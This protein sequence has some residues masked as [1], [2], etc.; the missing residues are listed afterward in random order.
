[1]KFDNWDFSV[2]FGGNQRKYTGTTTTNQ[3]INGGKGLL[4]PNLFTLN[5]IAPDNLYYNTY[6]SNKQVNSLYGLASIGF[7][8][9]FYLDVTGRNDWSSTLPDDNNSYFYPSVSGSLL[10]NN[11]FDMGDK[12]SL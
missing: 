9:F 4:T 6:T 7:R 12:I 11:A 8:N 3:T 1:K 5:N 2:S 10:L